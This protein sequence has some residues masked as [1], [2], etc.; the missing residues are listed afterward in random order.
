MRPLPPRLH[1]HFRRSDYWKRDRRAPVFSRDGEVRDGYRVSR[2]VYFNDVPYYVENDRM[3]RPLPDK[4]RERFRYSPPAQQGGP[5]PRE[6]Q[7]RYQ[8]PLN[9]RGREGEL[10]RER[11]QPPAYGRE[12]ERERNLPPAYGREPVREQERNQSPAYQQEQ[13]RER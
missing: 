8:P 10:E 3:A 1:D 11:N 7:P 13:E 12:R 4:E 2:V 6:E 5:M 9:G